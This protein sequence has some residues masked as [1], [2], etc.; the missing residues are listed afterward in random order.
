MHP[1][2]VLLAVYYD[3]KPGLVGI[4]KMPAILVQGVLGIFKIPANG[5][6]CVSVWQLVTNCSCVC[7][8]GV[9][10]QSKEGRHEWW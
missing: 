4:A 8:C 10:M 9:L 7:V 5:G 2:P 3:S 1:P 6:V